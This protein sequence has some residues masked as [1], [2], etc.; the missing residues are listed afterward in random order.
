MNILKSLRKPYFATFLGFLVLFVSCSQY[1]DTN[2]QTFDSEYLKS[3]HLN[4]KQIIENSKNVSI[5]SK[6][7]NISE[8]EAEQAYL[9]NLNYLNENG[10]ESLLQLHNIDLEVIEEFEFYKNNESNENVYDLLVANFNID[11]EQEA[12]FLFTAIEIYNQ[13][14]ADIDTSNSKMSRA[15]AKRISW[16][17]AFSIAGTVA[18]TIGAIWVTGG[19]ALLYFIFTKGLATAA[20]IEACGDGWGDM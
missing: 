11:S 16:G 1:E 3:T 14:D 2:E 17:C 12:S 9:Q 15:E 13:L 18:V 4:L 20:L 19:G 5:V 8:D 6:T 7:S 10:V